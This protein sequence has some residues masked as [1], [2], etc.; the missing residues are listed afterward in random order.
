MYAYFNGELADINDNGIIIDVN[1]VGYNIMMP[2]GKV[3]ELGDIGDIIKIYTYTC[4]REDAINLYGFVNNEE[5]K[6]FKLLITV[7]GIGPKGAMAIISV[8]DT[9]D[10]VSAI[11]SGDSNAIA[12][13]PGV[14]KKTAER[15]IIDL[16]DKVSQLDLGYSEDLFNGKY[17]QKLNNSNALSIECQDAVAA[18]QA[19]GYSE[20]DSKTAVIK[21][22]TEAKNETNDITF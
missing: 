17:M 2:A 8:M 7:S 3:Y 5:L 9:C 1:G 12:K 10:I 22:S 13:A 20:N 16:K 19:L 15:V 21:A 14:G 18:L 6:L 11:V 4:V